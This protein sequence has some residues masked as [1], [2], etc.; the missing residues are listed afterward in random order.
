M[1]EVAVQMKKVPFL[2]RLFRFLNTLL[3]LQKFY[4]SVDEVG[5]LAS[6]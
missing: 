3:F 6:F 4:A 2:T 5:E 1:V